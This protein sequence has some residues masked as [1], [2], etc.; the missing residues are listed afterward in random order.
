MGLRA[1]RMRPLTE[2]AHTATDTRGL[3]GQ[4]HTKRVIP[5]VVY[6]DGKKLIVFSAQFE[7]NYCEYSTTKG[8]VHHVQITVVN[9]SYW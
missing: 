2:E 4:F 3:K 5:C 1:E 7:V 6:L 9:L 8:A